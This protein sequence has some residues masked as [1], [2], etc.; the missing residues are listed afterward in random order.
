LACGGPGQES[1][2]TEWA[3]TYR[4]GKRPLVLHDQ[5]DGNFTVANNTTATIDR[6]VAA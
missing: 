2:R 6:I 4:N 1:A 3:A 5:I